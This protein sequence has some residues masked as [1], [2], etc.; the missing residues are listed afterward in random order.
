MD[1]KKKVL[2][3]VE[4]GAVLLITAAA[5][6]WGGRQALMERGYAAC[7]GECMLI[8]VPVLYYIGKAMVYTQ[9]Q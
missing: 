3:A 4:L 1:R 6:L 8:L 7:G 2:M 5:L 9:R